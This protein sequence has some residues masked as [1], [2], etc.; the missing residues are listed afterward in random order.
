MLGLTALGKYKSYSTRA[1]LRYETQTH[2]NEDGGR[3]VFKQVE[4]KE[5][6]EV[7]IFSTWNSPWAHEKH[8]Q[9]LKFSKKYQCKNYG[10]QRP[11]SGI[12]LVITKLN[13][14]KLFQKVILKISTKS[15]FKTQLGGLHIITKKA[16]QTI[17]IVIIN[18]LRQLATFSCSSLLFF[19]HLYSQLWK[20]QF[21]Y[22]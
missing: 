20:P 15:T 1:T 14:N 10:T 6:V 8:I 21:K 4:G 18:M 16:N 19:S 12:C 17:L 7:S 11:I 5:Q 3:N 13:N 2:Y 22:N 9:P